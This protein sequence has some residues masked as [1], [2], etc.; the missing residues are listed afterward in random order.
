MQGIEIKLDK[1]RHVRFGT[2]NLIQA[3]RALG[4]GIADIALGLQK[5]PTLELTRAMLW[6]GLLPEDPALTIEKVGE[7]VTPKKISTI[8]PKLVEALNPWFEQDDTP[9]P[10]ADTPGAA[11][12]PSPG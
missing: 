3:E 8:W 7:W 10:L 4:I 5:R 12:E 9:S 2:N 11:S 6:A 1:V